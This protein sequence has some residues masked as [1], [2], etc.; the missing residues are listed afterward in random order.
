MLPYVSPRFDAREPR[1]FV[2]ERD[3]CAAEGAVKCY[4]NVA[5][6][7]FWHCGRLG[8]VAGNWMMPIRDRGAV[9]G[10]ALGHESEIRPG[11]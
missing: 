8:K 2:L 9:R 4:F 6:I 5:A 3:L 10:G 1:S 11:I 7:E